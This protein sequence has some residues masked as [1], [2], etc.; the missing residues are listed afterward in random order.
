MTVSDLW[1]FPSVPWVGLQC[2]IVVFSDNTHLVPFKI[3]LLISQES[4]IY[5][6]A[7]HFLCLTKPSQW[8]SVDSKKF[9]RILFSRI[10]LK[11]VLVI[12]KFVTKARFTYINKRQSDFA[13]S[14][15][16][17]FHEK[18]AK[19]R[20]NKVLAKIFRI[21]SM[22]R[23]KNQI[24]I[25][26]ISINARVLAV[27]SMGSGDWAYVLFVN[28]ADYDQTQWIHGWVE[29]SLHMPVCRF[30]RAL[31]YTAKCNRLGRSDNW[32]ID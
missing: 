5:L 28:N 11:D 24:R 32:S 27:Y 16:V 1:L 25:R 20:E 23:A 14:R 18:Y 12:W 26:I 4:C 29:S 8:N 30:C 3:Y 9:A 22:Q 2:V 21:Y 19:L 6:Q 13:I 7:I 17:C 10:A 31:A 15:G